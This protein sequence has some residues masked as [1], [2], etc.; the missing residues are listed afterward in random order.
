M[1]PLYRSRSFILSLGIAFALVWLYVLGTR[2]LVPTDEGRYAEMGREMLVSGDWIT[3]R[4]NG[5]K[6]FEKPPLQT[7]MN[8]LSFG[9]FGLGEWQARLWTGLCGLAGVGLVAVAAR[10]VFNPHAGFLAA[11]VLGS[12]FYWVALGHINTLDMGLSCMMTL[13]LCSLLIAQ[14]DAAA[15]AER[16]NWMLAC[17]AGMAL[18]VLSKGLIGIVLPGGV[19]VLYTIASR[20][21]AIWKRLHIAKGLALFLLIT[22]PWFILVSLKNPE[23][24]YFFFIHEHFERFLLKEHHREGGWYYFIPLLLVGV[25]PWLGMLFQGLASGFRREAAANFQPRKLLAVWLIFI[26]LF[27][28][29]SKSKLP[30]YILPVFP[31]LALLIGAYMET[32]SRKTWIVTAGLIAALGAVGLPFAF[33]VASMAK[34]PLEAPLYAAYQPWVVA[35]ALVALAGG[36]FTLLV[37][38]MRRNETDP[39]AVSLAITGFILV[40]VLMQGHEPLG[41]NSSGQPLVGAINA[42]LTLTTPLYALGRYDQ[43]LP[44][45]LRRTMTMVEH[46]DE[47]S[48]GL[49]QQPELWLPTRALFLE[50][51]TAGPKSV[52]VTSPSIYAEL[53]KMNVPMRVIARDSRRVVITNEVKK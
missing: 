19:L 16:R 28:S 20:D 38:R 33:R 23:F 18:A 4:L 39:P 27:F 32:A 43:T 21:W 50:K 7:W 44:F 15:P 52:A 13:A 35:A 5:I 36:L 10:K 40:L 25:L 17:W 49:S 3:T 46:A 1:T 29:F 31:A 22:A 30:S 8:A 11:L 14:R 37:L 42:E 9:L 26:F 12:S 6:Y 45:Y 47:L 24:P 41:R 48:Y 2:T 34:H 51:W 53:E